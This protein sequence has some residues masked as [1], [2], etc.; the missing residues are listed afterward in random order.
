ME[1]LQSNEKLITGSSTNVLWTSF[2][3]R[4]YY[5][6]KNALLLPNKVNAFSME[7]HGK[8]PGGFCSNTSGI[9]EG[10]AGFVSLWLPYREKLLMQDV[11][12]CKQSVMQW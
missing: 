10:C 11:L 6:S 8:C 4:R 3:K 12:V 9:G 7:N 1:I 5:T 2:I